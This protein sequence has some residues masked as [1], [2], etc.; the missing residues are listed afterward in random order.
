MALFLDQDFPSPGFTAFFT[1]KISVS[2][3]FVQMVFH[4]IGSQIKNRSQSLTGQIWIL[5]Q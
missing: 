2:L 3:E 5:Y 1:L 4:A